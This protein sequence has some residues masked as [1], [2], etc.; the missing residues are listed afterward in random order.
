MHLSLRNLVASCGFF[1]VFTDP[2][3]KIPIAAREIPR[4][5]ILTAQDIAWVDTTEGADH[6]AQRVAKNSTSYTARSEST[7]VVPGWVAR[8]VI[9]KGERLQ[10]PAVSP[11]DLVT[12]G[13]SVHAVYGEGG[14]SVSFTAT[15]VG[16]GP[17]G[18]TIVIR[19]P[20]RKRI[21]AVVVAKNTV[22]IIK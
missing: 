14:V 22:R 3:S 2:S 9:R 16:S 20:N 7:D 11:P 8:R 5:T 21:P 10:R 12:T 15:A 1:C 18:D 13:S 17:Y 4:G 19:T 6:I